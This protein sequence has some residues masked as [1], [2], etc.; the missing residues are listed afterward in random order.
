MNSHVLAI[1]PCHPTHLYTPEVGVFRK[2]NSLLLWVSY[3]SV[4]LYTEVVAIYREIG[5][6]D[7]EVR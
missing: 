3:R 7:E 4:E 2:L 1:V 5:G 6:N